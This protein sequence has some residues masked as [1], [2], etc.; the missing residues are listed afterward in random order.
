MILTGFSAQGSTGLTPLAHGQR[1]GVGPTGSVSSSSFRAAAAELSPLAG[2]LASISSLLCLKL[3]MHDCSN[4]ADTH[5][6]AEARSLAMSAK[7][8]K[9]RAPLT[10]QLLW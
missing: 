2:A 6:W 1:Q 9:H 5:A 10:Q 7:F 8:N 4:A 3:V